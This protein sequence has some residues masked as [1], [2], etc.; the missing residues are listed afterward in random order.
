MIQIGQGAA[1]PG[2]GRAHSLLAAKPPSLR[3]FAQ[4]ALTAA[5]GGG[6]YF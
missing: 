6:E 1:E 4:V 2:M 5:E 3:V